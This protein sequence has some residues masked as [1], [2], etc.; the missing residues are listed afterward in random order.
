ML[1]G[2]ILVLRLGL[3]IMFT[4]HGLQMALGLF[5][6]PGVNGFS[7]MI[8]G[9]GF[10]P[11]LLWAYV[12]CY[13]VLIGGIF[14]ILGVFTRLSASLLLV[15]I[16]TAALK[17]HLSKG[18]FMAAGGFEYNFVIAASCLAL[19]LIGAGKYTIFMLM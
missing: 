5:G 10:F 16:L 11:P 13:T 9:L 6:G 2:G 14:L 4:A 18:F 12:A 1:N 7:K 17:V 15:F 8:A 19:I 3:G